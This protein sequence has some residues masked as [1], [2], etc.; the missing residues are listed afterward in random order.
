[1]KLSLTQYLI[2]KPLDRAWH[3][4]DNQHTL[5]HG[6]DRTIPQGGFLIHVESRPRIYKRVKYDTK[7]ADLFKIIILEKEDMFLD[8][9]ELTISWRA[10]HGNL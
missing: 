5:A 8:L 7:K 1:M 9:K 2:L 3:I 4:E 6:T 10:R